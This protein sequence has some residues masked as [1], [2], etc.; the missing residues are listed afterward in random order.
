MSFPIL[1]PIADTGVLVEFGDTIDDATLDKVLSFD[2]AL[3]Q[4]NFIG[5]TDRVPTATCVLVGYNPLETDFDSVCEHI[6]KHLHNTGEESST[7][8]HWQIPTCYAEP[9]APDLS[10][11]ADALAIS[12]HDVVEQHYSGNYKVTMYGF[13]PGYAYLGGVP[14]KIQ[15]PRKSGPV[16]NVPAQTVM[17]AGVQCL[18]TTLTMPTGWWRIGMTTFRPLQMDKSNPFL[19]NVGDTLE[20]VPMS[21]PDYRHHTSTQSGA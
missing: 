9:F 6:E 7:T 4:A 15:L 14:D 10:A 8:T 19:L 2:A 18:I 3:S 21:E 1:R 12:E 11:V 20:F 5:H 17:I 13:A 16:N